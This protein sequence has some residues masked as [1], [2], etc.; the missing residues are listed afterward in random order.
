MVVFVSVIVAYAAFMTFLYTT[1]KVKPEPSI[2]SVEALKN[3][4][5][6]LALSKLKNSDIDNNFNM[7][8]AAY[9]G[10]KLPAFSGFNKE[11]ACFSYIISKEEFKKHPFYTKPMHDKLIAI[12]KYLEKNLGTMSQVSEFFKDYL[13]HIESDAS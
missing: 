10:S 5:L 2:K 7:M 1:K 9:D 8:Y 12:D 13:K 11:N 6:S 4:L 3:A